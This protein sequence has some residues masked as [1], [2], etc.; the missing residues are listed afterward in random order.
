MKYSLQEKLALFQNRKRLKILF[1]FISI[2]FL[3][4]SDLCAYSNIE[5]NISHDKKAILPIR[6]ID[7]GS[8]SYNESNLVI[9]AIQLYSVKRGESLIEIARKFGI[10]Y[11]E[12]ADANPSLD[13]FVPGTG[14][15][16]ILHTSWILPDVEYYEGIVIN[17][18]ELRLYYFFKHKD[19]NFVKTFPIGIGSEGNNTPVGEFRVVEK[20]VNPPWYVPESIRKEEPQLPAV[21]PP[22][23]ENPLGSHA[24]RLSSET[25]LIH[26]TNRPW[27]VGRRVSHGCIR[28]YP[29]DIPKLFKLVSIG[30]KVTI[31]RQPIEVGTRD[32]K[33]FI[34]AH[35]D[36]SM[37]DM[38]YFNE[39]V[40]LLQK[41]DFLKRVSTDKLYRAIIEKSGIPVDITR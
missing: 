38:N 34:E 12:I 20:I 36:A 6:A 4:S 22:G 28:L 37:K 19:K 14:T 11:N 17:L 25:I 29:E 1:I 15:R 5:K 23:P 9:G 21:V 35:A 31:I 33:V 24:L 27:G 32:N 8:Y 3:F 40:I 26:G 18:S 2:V 30:T 39:A 16:V 41:K 13:P 7:G 10:G